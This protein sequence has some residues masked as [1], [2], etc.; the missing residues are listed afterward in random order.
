M[1]EPEW[2]LGAFLGVLIGPAVLWTAFWGIVRLIRW[3]W[4]RLKPTSG[5]PESN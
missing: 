4:H 5:T 3:A 2:L 1:I